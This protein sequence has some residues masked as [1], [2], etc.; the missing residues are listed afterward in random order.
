MAKGF[1]QGVGTFCL[2]LL[3]WFSALGCE[4]S[5][6]DQSHGR[7]PGPKA[8]DRAKWNAHLSPPF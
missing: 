8:D 2:C 3:L 5:Q 6:Q 1:L 7:S 4:A